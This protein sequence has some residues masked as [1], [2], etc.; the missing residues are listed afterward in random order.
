MIDS[1][2]G[3]SMRPGRQNKWLRTLAAPETPID[4]KILLCCAVSESDGDLFH[5]CTGVS[6]MRTDSL[7]LGATLTYIN[8]PPAAGRGAPK[9]SPSRSL[10]FLVIFLLLQESNTLPFGLFVACFR[11]CQLYSLLFLSLLQHRLSLGIGSRLNPRSAPRP[12]ARRPDGPVL[13]LESL[14]Q[15]DVL[16]LLAI[17]LPFVLG[18]APTTLWR[19]RC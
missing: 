7:E 6:G 12:D 9:L 11:R 3:Y 18:R 5:G 8:R 15:A 14:Q 4:W 10:C 1:H 17:L 16:R 13:L 19:G 2:I